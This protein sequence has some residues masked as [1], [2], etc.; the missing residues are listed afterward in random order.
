MKLCTTKQK[1]NIFHVQ[2][3]T[4]SAAYES[5]VALLKHLINTS[6]TSIVIT[7]IFGKG[8]CLGPFRVGLI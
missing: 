2:L 1:Q 4:K 8:H 3:F 7:E 6:A 5:N